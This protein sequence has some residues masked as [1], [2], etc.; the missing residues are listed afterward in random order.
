MTLARDAQI[1]VSADS[2]LIVSSR[3]SHR[4][5]PRAS[6]AH[7]SAAR[8]SVGGYRQYAARVAS[9]S[10]R[11]S[12]STR[13]RVPDSIRRRR[14]STDRQS[15]AGLRPGP[16]FGRCAGD[17]D[18]DSGIS[19]GIRPQ[20][21]RR[22]R[23]RYDSGGRP[24]IRGFRL[25]IGR[26]LPY[27]ECGRHCGIWRREKH[28]RRDG[29]GRRNRSISRSAGRR[30]LHESRVDCERFDAVRAGPDCV[31]SIRRHPAA[32][33]G[34]V[35]GAERARAAGRRATARPQQHRECRPILG[36]STFSPNMVGMSAR[37]YAGC[38]QGSGPMLCGH[39]DRGGTG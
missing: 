32:R 8:P 33:W 18:H 36:E 27:R 13:L 4:T 11:H 10:E 12:A 30:E 19:G 20:A 22:D 3:P 21:G 38:R 23:G 26:E 5:A 29:L 28:A 35:P 2:T 31:E 25:R 16:R 7:D 1:T 39:A 24:R 34:P 17:D 6:R 15:L 9:R 14:S 37:W